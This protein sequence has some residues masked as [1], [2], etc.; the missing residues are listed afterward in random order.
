MSV[1]HSG[2]RGW[3]GISGLRVCLALILKNPDDKLQKQ[4]FYIP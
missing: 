3:V 4:L 2:F 1:A